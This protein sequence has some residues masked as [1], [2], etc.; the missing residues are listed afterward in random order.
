MYSFRVLQVRN[1]LT[2]WSSRGQKG[3]VPSKALEN[4]L[5]CFEMLSA[6]YGVRPCITVNLGFHPHLFPSDFDPLSSLLTRTLVITVVIPRLS[7]ALPH[8]NILHLITPTKL[9]LPYDVTASRESG[10]DVIWGHYSAYH[11]N[12]HWQHDMAIKRQGLSQT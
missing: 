7:R 4:V 3:C 2:S 8:L 12:W 1:C 10:I 11:K 6:F 9:Y 5:P